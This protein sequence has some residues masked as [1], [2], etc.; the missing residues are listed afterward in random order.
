MSNVIQFPRS[1]TGGPPE[2]MDELLDNITTIRRKQI[3]VIMEEM[4]PDLISL[5]ESNG[6]DINQDD[7]VKDT[8]MVI[9]AMKSALYRYYGIVHPF[10]ST[11]ENLFDFTVNEDGTIGYVYTVEEDAE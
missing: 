3:D 10:H 5:F 9:E 4:V 11:M 2:S 6:V 7:Y 8:A 1:K